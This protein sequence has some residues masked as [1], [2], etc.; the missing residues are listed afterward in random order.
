MDLNHSH[1]LLAAPF[2]P[3]CSV[4]R[5]LEL[6]QADDPSLWH[7]L[8]QLSVEGDLWMSACPA[9]SQYCHSTQEA[10]GENLTYWL[11][12]SNHASKSLGAT[13]PPQTHQSDK[14]A[15]AVNHASTERWCWTVFTWYSL[16]SAEV[17]LG[18]LLF[19]FFPPILLPEGNR[20]KYYWKR[21]RQLIY[22]L[23]EKA[24][25]TVRKRKEEWGQ[26]GDRKLKLPISCS[27][28]M[29]LITRCC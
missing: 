1:P 16:A 19:T 2:I 23:W 28:K 24:K 14:Q 11:L 17:S 26:W 13:C 25:H 7:C 20:Y 3:N 15:K 22:T 9:T 6:W 8:E 5:R 27:L 12:R 18:F 10:N 29:W 21:N 4:S